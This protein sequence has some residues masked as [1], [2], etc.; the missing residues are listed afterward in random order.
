MTRRKPYV[1]SMRGWWLGNGHFMRYMLREATSVFLALYAVVLLAGLVALG[2]GEASYG[3]W[4]AA[5]T[6]PG[7]VVFHLCVLAAAGYHTVTW[8]AVSPKAMPPVRLGGAPVPARAIIG[9]Q[10]AACAVIS[11]V[12]LAAAWSG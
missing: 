12:V 10:Y 6:H 4:L 3:R 1:R 11:L 9:G 8:F 5:M 7:F 2:L